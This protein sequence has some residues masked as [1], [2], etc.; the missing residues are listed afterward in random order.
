MAQKFEILALALAK[1]NG[2]DEPG[3]KAFELRNPLMLRTYKPEKRADSEHYRIF[4]TIMGGFKAGVAELSARCSGK[5]HR[6][7][8][9][10][11]LRDLLTLYGFKNDLAIRKITLFCRKALAD[12]SISA[13]TPLAFFQEEIQ[14]LTTP[15]VQGEANV[16]L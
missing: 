8:S 9:E 5:N 15:E 16:G 2:W 6:L 10:N 7:N 12:D 3:M 14:E 13:N 1:S 11:T 4:S